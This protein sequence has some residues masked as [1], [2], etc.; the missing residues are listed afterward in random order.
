MSRKKLVLLV[1]DLDMENMIKALLGRADSFGIEE[2][3][4]SHDYDIYRHQGRDPGCRIGAADFLRS[5]TESYEHA[6]VL[7][8]LEG[9]GD[10]I[11]PIDDVE[12]EVEHHLSLSGWGERARVIAIAPELESWVWSPSPHVAEAINWKGR[13]PRIA[14]WLCTNGWT[15]RVGEKPSRPKEALEAA[16]RAVGRPRSPAVYSAIGS[17]ASFTRCVDRSFLR[18]KN[19][20]KLWFGKRKIEA[21]V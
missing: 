14:D 8:D 9:C 6:L 21:N 10:E 5:F 3:R 11:R 4:A 16:L 12:R 13:D 1:A 7:F 19:T 18:F 20:L 17:H 15:S 2:L